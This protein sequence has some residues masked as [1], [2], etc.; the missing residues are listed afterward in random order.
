MAAKWAATGG[1]LRA[2]VVANGDEGDPGSFADRLLMEEDPDRVLEGLALACFACGARE[3]VVL[4]RSEYPKALSRMREAVERAYADGHPGARVHGSEMTLDVRVVA[5]AG[6][7]VAGEETALIDGLEGGRGCS[8]PPYPTDQGLRD[9]PTV[10]NN[11]ETLA[12]VPWIVAHGGAAYARRG[13]PAQTGTEQPMRAKSIGDVSGFGCA[14]VSPRVC[15][16]D[17]G[18]W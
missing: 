11:V 17:H 13:V 8:R 2:V 9:A 4:V 3:A 14:A 1:R 12:A 10:V 5:G 6:S 16:V 7:Y 18:G 15:G